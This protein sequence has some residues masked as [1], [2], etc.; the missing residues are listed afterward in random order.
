MDKNYLEKPISLEISGHSRGYV[1]GVA[2][3]DPDT[4]Q[5]VDWDYD[6]STYDIVRSDM[7]A[8]TDDIPKTYKE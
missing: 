8:D 3:Y 7:E 2:Y 1:D 4:K 5:L 6:M